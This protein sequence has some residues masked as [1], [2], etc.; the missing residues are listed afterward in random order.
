MN[1]RRTLS[2]SHHWFGKCAA[3]VLLGVLSV[4]SPGVARAEQ[5]TI[6]SGTASGDDSSASMFVSG[7]NFWFSLHGE[8]TGLVSNLGSMFCQDQLVRPSLRDAGGQQ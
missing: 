6:T 3:L 8:T 2:N 1:E 5:F 7:A 4:A